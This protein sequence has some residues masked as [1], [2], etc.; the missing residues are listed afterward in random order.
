MFRQEQ[1]TRRDTDRRRRRSDEAKA[2]QG[3]EPI[4]RR[5]DS[6]LTVGRVRITRG[7]VV[8][9]YRVLARPQ[10]RKSAGLGRNRDRVDHGP[11][12]AGPDPQ[13]VQTDL[14]QA[15]HS[16]CPPTSGSL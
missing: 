12:G 5:R 13:G 3:I 7:Q 1:N 14:H 2:D 9:H 16:T 4:G 15:M 8:E 10:R 11:L 6:N